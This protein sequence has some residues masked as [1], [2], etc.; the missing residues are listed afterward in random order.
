MTS[1]RWVFTIN[2]PTLE[3]SLQCS[4]FLE[5]ES[6]VKYA[7]LGR[8][9]GESGTHHFQ[10]F[11]VLRSPQRQRWVLRH[12]GGRA[13]LEKARGTSKEASDYC[14]KGSDFDEWGACPADTRYTREQSLQLWAEVR[15]AAAEGRFEDIRDDVYIRF[16]QAL[17]GIWEENLHATNCIDELD[18]IWI[19]GATGIGKSRW[20]FQHY[21][22]AYRKPLNKWWDHY[23]N[24]EVVLIEDI[25]PTHSKW[26]GA[27][28]KIWSDHYPFISERKGGS[29]QI[30]PKKIIV[31]SNYLPTQVF[32]DPGIY[33]PILRRFAVKTIDH[34]LLVNYVNPSNLGLSFTRLGPDHYRCN[35]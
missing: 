6:L 21:P 5:D 17:R 32:S 1:R 25:D 8:E 2:N 11:V 24:E 16:R 15:Q 35:E 23:T 13:F 30:R 22:D 26:I 14:K 29:R 20:A 4:A 12:L 7:V 18:N 3:D 28:L 19:Y 9:V 33:N 27:Y 10:G 31:T 34:G